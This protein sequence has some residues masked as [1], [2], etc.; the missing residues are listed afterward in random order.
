MTLRS[1]PSNI[2]KGLGGHGLCFV[3]PLTIAFLLVPE[4]G[5]LLPSLSGS[6][7]RKTLP[8]GNE[9]DSNPDVSLSEQASRFNEM[10]DLKIP[11]KFALI[12]KFPLVSTITAS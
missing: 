7:F 4:L 8:K 12:D 10:R 2:L 5:I 3:S 9:I 6:R 11:L 1:S